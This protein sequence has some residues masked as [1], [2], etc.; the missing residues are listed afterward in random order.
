MRSMLEGIRVIDFTTTVAGPGCTFF[1]CDL[2]AEVIKVEKPGS[3]DEAR[4]FPPYKGNQSASFAVLN[5]GKKGIT[6]DL[7]KPEGVSLFKEL[8]LKSDVLVENFRPG[9]MERLG[10]SYNQLKKIN[11]KLVMCSISG[12]GQYGPLSSQPAYD[13]VIQAMSGLMSTTGY[14]DGPPLRT[15]TLIVDICSAIY[16]AFGICAALFAREKTGEGEYLDVAMFDVAIQL[17]E[18]KFVDYTV[19][20]NIPQRTGN[21][22]PYVTPFD[23]FPTA[24]GLIFIICV[25]DHPFQGLCD[26]MGQPELPKDDRFSNFIVRNENEPALKQLIKKWTKQYTTDALM[27]K[28]ITNGVPG[29]P[30]NDVKQVVEHPHTK[31]RGMIVGIDQPGA[32]IIQIFAPA[33]KALNSLVEIRGAAPGLGEDNRM[34]LERVLEKSPQEIET[35]L[36]SGGMG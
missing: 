8:I 30:V 35:I 4:L 3:G 7:K 27:E 29:A 11:P 1:L 36:S 18:A 12:Y 19:T 15:G 14:P 28:L 5:R 33:L 25:G 16:A 10:L 6:L 21:R 20:G 26:A 9:V 23:T 24:D 13:A 22:Y 34:I 32:G 17:L 31:A 2:G